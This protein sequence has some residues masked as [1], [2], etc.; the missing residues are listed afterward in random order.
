[1]KADSS[2]L[3]RKCYPMPEHAN[4]ALKEQGL[5]QAYK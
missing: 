2:K 4:Q 1:M 3:K 5:M